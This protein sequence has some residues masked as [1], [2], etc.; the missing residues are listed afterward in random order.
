M[1]DGDYNIELMIHCRHWQKRKTHSWKS[2]FM[3]GGQNSSSRPPPSGGVTAGIPQ[4][5]LTAK[6]IK[7]IMNNPL[8][9]KEKPEILARKDSKMGRK[10][11]LQLSE[12]EAVSQMTKSEFVALER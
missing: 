7:V 3:R 8:D 1:E 5:V 6:D 10:D 4:R 9:A 12:K 2:L 11:K